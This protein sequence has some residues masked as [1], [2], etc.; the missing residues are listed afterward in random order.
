MTQVIIAAS[1]SK[2]LYILLGAIV[3]FILEMCSFMRF[4]K[5]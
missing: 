4:I 1:I 2:M 3:N 5:V